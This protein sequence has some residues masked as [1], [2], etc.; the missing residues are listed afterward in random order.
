MRFDK[1]PYDG[2]NALEL[3]LE[4]DDALTVGHG[5]HGQIRELCV[6]QLNARAR[7]ALPEVGAR[8]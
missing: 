1:R 6:R 7:Q 5:G 8:L 4:L 3:E 2:P